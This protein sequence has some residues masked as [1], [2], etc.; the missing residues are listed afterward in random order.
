MRGTIIFWL[1]K[2]F[3]LAGSTWSAWELVTDGCRRT[4]MLVMQTS[5][6]R[7]KLDSKKESNLKTTFFTII[8]WDSWTSRIT[9]TV[10]LKSKPPKISSMPAIC[11]WGEKDELTLTHHH[12][13]LF[14]NWLKLTQVRSLAIVEQRVRI[15]PK[16]N[17]LVSMVVMI[18]SFLQR[19]FLTK[20]DWWEYS[21]F[22][23]QQN[24]FAQRLLL[25][26]RH[27]RLWSCWGQL[28]RL[29]QPC[30]N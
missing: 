28:W 27:L 10:L 21:W 3:L 25:Q 16:Q 8:R 4:T 6:I 14:K 11:E 1:T 20:M 7:W 19:Y 13:M 17:G 22:Y 26:H 9:T 18:L 2:I 15:L 12:K 5:S 29:L 24:I 23:P 30:I